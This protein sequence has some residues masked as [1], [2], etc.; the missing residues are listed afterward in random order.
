MYAQI[1]TSRR[2]VTEELDQRTRA[3]LGQFFTPYPIAR[4]MASLFHLNGENAIRLLDAG[5]GIGSLSVA[6]LEQFAMHKHTKLEIVAYEFDQSIVPVLKENL[7]EF[8]VMTGIDITTEVIKGDFIRE[9][10]I[11]CL[12]GKYK[13]VDYV[14]LNPPYRKINSDS[15]HRLLLRKVGIETVNLYAAFVALSLLFL[16]DGGELVAIIPRSFCNGPYFRPFRTFLLERAAIRHIHIFGARDKAFKE[17]S[18]LQENIILH[19]VK[20]VSQEAVKISS[21][22]GNDFEDYAEFKVPFNR[23]VTADD[24]EGFIHIPGTERNLYQPAFDKF[25]FSLADLDIMVSTGPVVDFRVK[26]FL[27]KDAEPDAAPLL[28]PAHFGDK[29]INWPKQNFKKS[30]ALTINADTKR[31]LFPTGFYTLVRRFS[32]KEEKRRIV[33]RVVRPDDVSGGYI[34][35]ENHLN[36]FHKAKKGLPEAMALGL[37]VYL[38]STLIDEYFR[39]FNGH[40]QV[41]ATDLRLLKYPDKEIL[42]DLGLWA[43][44]LPDFEQSVIDAKITSL[45]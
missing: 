5:A 2:V 15:D 9:G 12:L 14:I 3:D 44:D 32:A 11:A 38:N 40:T 1:D 37:A 45:L 39:Q 28:Y 43:K 13:P 41:N 30:N 22:S 33:A 21:S 8:S 27:L 10:V 4:F 36:V 20:G 16:K 31:Q 34:G 18:V 6:F 23:I 17:D 7:H 42:F 26:D 25:S 19:L 29:N 24:S 35:F